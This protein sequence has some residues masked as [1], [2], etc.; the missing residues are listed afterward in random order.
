MVT[1]DKM[2]TNKTT[3]PLLCPTQILSTNRWRF[4]NIWRCFPFP[5]WWPNHHP[6]TAVVA[7]VAKAHWWLLLP[8][9]LILDIPANNCMA[10]KPNLIA[11]TTHGNLD[12]YLAA[13]SSHLS[14]THQRLKRGSNPPA[15]LS[16]TT[17]HLPSNYVFDYIMQCANVDSCANS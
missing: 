1:P 15:P 12:Q 14:C 10:S 3:T 8:P 9:L 6:I 13:Y 4:K 5:K 16:N 7:A 11:I 17:T 2:E